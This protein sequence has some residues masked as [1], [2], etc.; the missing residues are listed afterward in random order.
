LSEQEAAIGLFDDSGGNF[1]EFHDT[2][3]AKGRSEPIRRAPQT[4]FAQPVDR[5][6][7]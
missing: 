2:T 3:P 4:H 7:P 5:G 6:C 1:G